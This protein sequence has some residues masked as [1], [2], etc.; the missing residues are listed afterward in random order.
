MLT[1]VYAVG[2]VTNIG[3]PKSIDSGQA[4]LLAEALVIDTLLLGLFAVQH[5]VMARPAFKTL[6]TRLVP[7]AIERSIYVLFASLSLI[8]LFW[9]WRPFPVAI[10]SVAEPAA[11]AAIQAVSLAGFCLVLLPMACS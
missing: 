7:E 6:W 8:V 2:F 3:V 1:I 11:A 5:S 9:Q 10:W 4:G